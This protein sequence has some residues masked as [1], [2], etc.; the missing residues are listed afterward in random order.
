MKDELEVTIK[1]SIYE[2][3]KLTK[4]D[5]K[6]KNRK[7]RILDNIEAYK[8]A[9]KKSC[10]RAIYDRTTQQYYGPRNSILRDFKKLIE[11]TLE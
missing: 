3:K 7:G 8:E 10:K 11:G 4:K 1:K 6:G 9:H 2:K 5:R